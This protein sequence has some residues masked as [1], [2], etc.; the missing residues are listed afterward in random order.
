MAM[1]ADSVKSALSDTTLSQYL[2]PSELEILLSH[3]LIV[4]FS[5]GD[6]I[7]QQ[8][9][10]ST[11][12]YVIIEGGAIV[13]AKTLEFDTSDI[14][15]L[16][17]GDFIGEISLL[18]GEP[19]TASV[20]ANNATRCLYISNVYL[21]FL[22]AFFPDIK[23]KTLLAIA[24]EIFKRINRTHEKIVDILEKCEMITQPILGRVFTSFKKPV[25]TTFEEEN[26]DKEILK[27]LYPFLLFD[28]NEYDELL[29]HAQ[30]LKADKHCA[31]V[32]EGEKNPVCYI[33]IH[34]GVQSSSIHNNKVAKLSVIGPNTLFCSTANIDQTLQSKINFSTCENVILMKLADAELNVLQKDHMKIW[35]R[36]FDLCCKSLIALE[37][38]VQKLNI[39][40]NIE[41][42]NR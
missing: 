27:S 13:S 32:R 39:R 9:Q 3:V 6:V 29:K 17:R 7:L 26:I 4:S 41:L 2:G 30:L 5:Q 23:Y 24:N 16:S 22:S 28:K 20:I 38:S 21:Q 42:Y 8:G 37:R 35:A 34:G 12:I 14:A 40:L 31:L 36:L 19:S 1:L 33:V 15:T 10:H 18:L 11:G 25:I